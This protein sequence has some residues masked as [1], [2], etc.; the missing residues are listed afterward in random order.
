MDLASFIP[1]ITNSAAF[2]PGAT[3]P[4]PFNVSHTG[5]TDGTGPSTASKNMAEIYNRI[6]LNIAATVAKAG[7]TLDNNNWAQLATAVDTIA[8][9][10][11]SAFTSTIVT[12]PQFDSSTAI[13]TTTFVQRAL[14]NAS[15][16]VGVSSTPFALTSAH[17]GK[18]MVML[19]GSSV[20]NL[21]PTGAA[22][23]SMFHFVGHST[24]Q[25]VVNLTTGTFAPSNMYP[26]STYAVIRPRSQASFVWDTVNMFPVNGGSSNAAAD[27][28]F[29]DTGMITLESG[30]TLMWGV[31]ITSI[32][33][34]SRSVSFGW[35][36]PNLCR[37]VML[38][39]RSAGGVLTNNNVP[40]LVSMNTTSFTYFNQ[41]IAEPTTPVSPNQGVYWLAIGN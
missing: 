34:T 22:N 17:A 30:L 33:E 24:N 3:T 40:Q 27:Y 21:N 2:T 11:V 38:T 18:V 26:G 15:S 36:F 37:A 13:A 6:L 1:G 35:S 28:T 8:A 41:G 5:L 29:A 25:V 9:N 39:G 19:N 20:V 32:G 10:R 14:G 4:P 23:G 12:P 7:L 16:V 31:D